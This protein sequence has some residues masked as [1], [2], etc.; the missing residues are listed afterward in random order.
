MSH[1]DDGELTAYADGAYPV[2]DPD[3]LRI[4]AHLSACDNCRTR[5]EQ[6]QQL[7]E[8]ATEI[9]GYATPAA[10]TAPSF[11]TLQAQIATSP[12]RSRPYLNLAWAASIIMALGLGWY[13]RGYL[14]NPPEM[15]GSAM[16]DAP[17]ET[18][19]VS[20]PSGIAT[21]EEAQAPQ[22]STETRV[23]PDAAA[24]K[25]MADAAANT[26]GQ[27]AERAELGAAAGAAAAPAALPPAEVVF[28]EADMAVRDARF[29][30]AAEAERR[31][32]AFPRIPELPVARVAPGDTTIVEQTLPD[33]GVV[34]LAVVNAP[35]AMAAEN[36]QREQAAPPP[37]PARARA[38]AEPQMAKTQQARAPEV[39]VQLAGKIITLTGSLAPD[40]LQ[41]LAR[42]VR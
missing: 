11:E 31:G 9:L 39:T 32:I 38:A 37:A 34:R 33:G 21:P 14:Y 41:A 4:S 15:R 35:L 23:A 10:R 3:A 24:G 1:V 25:R 6:A 27:R 5:L 42:K 29:I 26:S 19:A 28:A 13:G 30:S 2:N 12:A 22:V 20:S 8:R 16:I 17:A 18:R 36:A 40:S 7:R